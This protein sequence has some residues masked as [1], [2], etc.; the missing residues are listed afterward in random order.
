M[1]SEQAQ[2]DDLEQD[3]LALIRTTADLHRWGRANAHGADMHE[4]IDIL[5]EERP[6]TDP[7]RFFRIVQKAL[8]SSLRVIWRA[9]DSSG[10]IGDAVRRLLDLHPDAA[11]HAQVKPATLV[12]WMMKFQ[13]DNEVDYFNLDIV[14]YAP[15]L[16]ETG[17]AL[18]RRRLQELAVSLGVEPTTDEL[19]APGTP[20][21]W[22]DLKYNYQRL[23]VLDRDVDA[24]IR[25]HAR[26]QR[27]AAWQ[28]DTAEAL[29]EI[30]E[31]DLAID[32]ARKATDF[33]RGHQSS[34]AARRWLRLVAEHRPDEH[35]AAVQHVFD[36]WPTS[37]NAAAVREVAGSRWAELRPA[38]KEALRRDPDEAVTFALNSGEPLRAWELAQELEPT[39]SFTWTA[40]ADAL[41]SVDPASAIQ[42]HMIL[43]EQTLAQADARNYRDGARRLAKMRTLSTKVG[44]ERA[45]DDFIESLRAE[46]RR[47][48][49]LQQEFDR[50]G[51]P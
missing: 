9:D 18:Y 12:N 16:G 17:V 25:T 36:R 46:H 48:P 19:W 24:I 34:S 20:H 38:V 14:L 30:G 10:V 40:L 31:F 15:V 42:L 22:S 1:D 49:R 4:A 28:E 6:E 23:A 39:S 41:G 3:V 7:A 26:D 44:K 32:W 2:H 21:Q 8:M 13:F 5:E 51:L 27:V 37:G 43:V 33:S 35:L 45:V 50:V 47:R 29:E 11:L